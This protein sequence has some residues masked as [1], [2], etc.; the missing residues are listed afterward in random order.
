MLFH[1]SVEPDPLN[2]HAISYVWGNWSRPFS[3]KTPEG[4]VPITASLHSALR[5]IRHAED[6]RTLWADG[7]CINQEDKQEKGHQVRLMPRI[8][9]SAHSVFAFV[10]EEADG[11]SHILLTMDI[12][13]RLSPLRAQDIIADWPA[14]Q[15]QRR[16]RPMPRG[17]E[18]NDIE[19]FARRAWFTRIWIVQEIVLAKQIEVICGNSRIRWDSLF[20]Y[21]Y[22]CFVSLRLT[23]S[24]PILC[25]D[26]CDNLTSNQDLQICWNC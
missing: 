10:G 3:L 21:F 17:K 1:V 22:H 26:I 25:L 15:W 4:I 19:A 14:V 9:K 20:E 18:W 12:D 2:Y 8:Y 7:V 16:H 24:L 23:A 13:S 5:A 11:S 6:F